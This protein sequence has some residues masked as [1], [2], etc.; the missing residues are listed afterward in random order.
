MAF[1]DFKPNWPKFWIVSCLKCICGSNGR[2]KNTPLCPS[3]NLKQDTFCE[4]G[5]LAGLSLAIGQKG[6]GR[7]HTP[8]ESHNAAPLA[9]PTAEWC[10]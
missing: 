6:Q 10:D 3:R 7:P 8:Q 2:S 1:V 4:L 9:R 5:Q